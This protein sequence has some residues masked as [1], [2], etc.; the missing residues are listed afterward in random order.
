MIAGCFWLAR[1]MARENVTA[2]EASWVIAF[3]PR[4][5][6]SSPAL[7]WNSFKYGV[8]ESGNESVKTADSA[9]PP[10]SPFLECPLGYILGD[11]ETF[12]FPPELGG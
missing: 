6:K 3:C 2:T 8:A 7:F 5:P 10:K 11:C 4:R 9:L 12:R 1:S